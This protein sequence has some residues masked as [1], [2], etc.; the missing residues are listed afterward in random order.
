[1]PKRKEIAES[2][3]AINDANSKINNITAIIKRHLA[4]FLPAGKSEEPIALAAL[5]QQ[6]ADAEGD[7]KAASDRSPTGRSGLITISN[8]I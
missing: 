1:M 6:R 5:T 3:K 8:S 7:L 2:Q 4:A